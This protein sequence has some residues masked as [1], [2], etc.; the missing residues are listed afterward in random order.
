MVNWGFAQTTKLPLINILMSLGTRSQGLTRYSLHYNEANV[1]Q[2]WIYLKH[3]IQLLLDQESQSLC[4]WS[5]HVGIF[6]VKRL[7]FGIETAASIFQ[8]TMESLLRNIPYVVVYQDDI[9][10]TGFDLKS[11][12]PTL[13]KVL[14][15][16]KSAGLHLNKEKTK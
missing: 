8:K 7:P 3:T 1:L 9:T 13:R 14:G 4:T 5:T 11:H 15:K 16:L 10:I 6:K 2:S 12:V